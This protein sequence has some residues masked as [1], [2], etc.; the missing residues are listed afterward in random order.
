MLCNIQDT[1]QIDLPDQHKMLSL[2]IILSG[3]RLMV[4]VGN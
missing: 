4:K 3:T 2:L 1:L